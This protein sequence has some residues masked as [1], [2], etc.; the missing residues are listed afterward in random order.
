MVVAAKSS[1]QTNQRVLD[2]SGATVVKPESGRLA[3]FM[4][5][6]RGLPERCWSDHCLHGPFGP[7][8]FGRRCFVD[9]DSCS[10]AT[11][12]KREQNTMQ[13]TARD[14]IGQKVIGPIAWICLDSH[15]C[16]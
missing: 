14:R 8:K 16:G 9:E 3:V 6:S 15:G 11:C 10:W 7:G 1:A 2:F 12:V 4:D 5:I 13:A